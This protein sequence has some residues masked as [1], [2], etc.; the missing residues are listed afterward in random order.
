V[1]WGIALSAEGPGTWRLERRLRG[2]LAA[3][4]LA[5]WTLGTGLALFSVQEET[6]EVLDSALIETAQVLLGLPDAAFDSGPDGRVPAGFGPHREYLVYQVFDGQGRM[7]LRSHQAPLQPL[8]PLLAMG[9]SEQGRWRVAALQAGP[10]RVLV[11][12]PLAHRREVIWETC[13]WL[14]LPLLLV[15]PLGAV[16]LHRVLRGVFG[17]L[18]PARQA[19]ERREELPL[20]GMPEELLPLLGAVNEMR[21]RLQHQ[22]EA[23]RAFASQM[24]HELRTPLAAAR[25]HAQR[26]L[27]ETDA[28]Q[29]RQRAQVL[30]RQ[31]DR[32]TALASRLLQMARVDAGL[33]LRREAVDL[34]LLARMVLDEFATD[35]QSSRLRLHAGEQDCVVQADLDALGIALRNLV[36]NALH[37]G[38]PAAHVDVF[39]EPTGLRVCDDG[40]GMDAQALQQLNAGLA[41]ARGR[42]GLGLPLVRKIAQQSGARLSLR[43]PLQQ[44]AGFEAALRF[45][46]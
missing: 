4:L 14:L 37:H 36:D 20:Q 43:S 19:L 28:Q 35:G 40:P 32:V 17:A 38:G 13:L 2:R 27:G 41:P 33:A 15:L 29:A 11:A 23:E 21:R 25:A 39:V 12:E 5:A 26:L 31:I 18:R 10:R 45:D 8:A 46:P 3:L 6:D 34:R 44:G 42:S 16:A 9:L 7:R 30:L 1:G 22:V 24:A